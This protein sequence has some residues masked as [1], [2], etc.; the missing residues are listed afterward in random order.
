MEDSSRSMSISMA[1]TR[2]SAS[3]TWFALSVLNCDK[4]KIARRIC[5]STRPPSSITREDTPFSSL[6]NWLDKCLSGI[7]S[8]YLLIQ[9]LAETSGDVVFGLFAFRLEE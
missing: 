4:A 5:D 2:A 8:F 3:T 7:N 9:A 6:S 1:L